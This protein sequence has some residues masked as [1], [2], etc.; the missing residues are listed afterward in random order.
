[1]KEF[2]A[3]LGENGRLIVPAF[4]RKN[5]ELNPD[6]S[7]EIYIIRLTQKTMRLKQ[8]FLVRTYQ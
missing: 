1:M 3:T 2:I 4:I 6:P 7:L 8:N 5:L